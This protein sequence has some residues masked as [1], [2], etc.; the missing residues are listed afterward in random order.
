MGE[1][2]DVF[3]E[4]LDDSES[5]IKARMKDVSDLLERHDRELHAYMEFNAIDPTFYSLRWIT[6]LLSRYSD[7][8]LPKPVLLICVIGSSTC[9]TPFVSGTPSSPSPLTWTAVIG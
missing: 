3:V 6:T 5:G 7:L 8:D 1:L 9:P 2:K 4:D